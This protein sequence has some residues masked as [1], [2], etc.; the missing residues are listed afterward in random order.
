MAVPV[1]VV[2]TRDLHGFVP[3]AS[4]RVVQVRRWVYEKG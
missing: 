3:E 2:F 4:Q 1:W